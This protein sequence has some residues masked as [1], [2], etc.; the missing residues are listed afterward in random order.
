MDQKLRAD[1]LRKSLASRLHAE[2]RRDLDDLDELVG[3]AQNSP[4][5]GLADGT[6]PEDRWYT[7]RDIVKT[8]RELLRLLE[9]A[10]S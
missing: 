3:E 5:Q 2:L 7:L 6:I 10:R 8:G 9:K 4:P 1:L